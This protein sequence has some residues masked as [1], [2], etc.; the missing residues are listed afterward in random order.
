MTIHLDVDHFL[1][2]VQANWAWAVG[3]GGAMFALNALAVLAH[4]DRKADIAFWLSGRRTQESWSRSFTALF[5][6]LFGD[7][8]LSFKCFFRSAIASLI[9][10]VLIWSLMGSAG[11]LGE[12]FQATQ[13]LGAVLLLGLFINVLA[14]YV[15]LLETRFLLG[16]MPKPFIAQ[17]GVLFLDLL[18]TA[19]IIWVFIF[20][21]I[22]SPLH[23]GEL[24]TF[25]EIL[26]VF[27]I[28]SVF[29]YSTF[30]TSFWT[31]AYIGSTWLMRLVA[32]LRVNYWFDVK[33]QPIKTLL[34]VLSCA[35]GGVAF[36]G[37]MVLAAPLT[38]G[39]DGLS[40]VDRALCSVFKGRVCVDVASLS[41][42]DQARLELVGPVIA[43]CDG[44]EIAECID[45]RLSA[46]GFSGGEAA[47]LF[48]MACD[49]GHAY[50][51]TSNG[52]LYES[53]IGVPKDLPRAFLNYRKACEGGHLGSCHN[54][55]FVVAFGEGV[56]R[57]FE[58]VAQRERQACE[59]GNALGCYNLAIFFEQGVG[60][61]E[62][63]FEAAIRLYREACDSGVAVSCGSLAVLYHRGIGVQ[64][65][66]EE[67]KRLYWQACQMGDD[68]A[69]IIGAG[70][71][72][73]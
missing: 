39:P 35:V 69:C 55:Y 42:E 53:G 11:T 46:F 8:H 23:E 21:Y 34:F 68:G 67:A 47:R 26:G 31:W 28:F 5:D 16:R 30:L 15:S 2:F 7:R 40:A 24:E 71:G 14:D 44:A 9:A 58:T 4:P 62:Q 32:K 72:T 20:A 45:S 25:A 59:S 41:H 64:I 50:S 1:A 6:G 61:E 19:G 66:P 63:D 43:A 27:S 48:E 56:E 65:N 18:I 70:L 36:L 54:L 73:P 17:L 10:V 12:R 37:S 49:S 38:K 57:D 52:S 33:G 29:F 60:V 3:L 22:N 51:C 13:T